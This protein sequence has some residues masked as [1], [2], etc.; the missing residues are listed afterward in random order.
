MNETDRIVLDLPSR[1]MNQAGTAGFS[2]G[3]QLLPNGSIF[4]TNPVSLQVRMPSADR[5]LLPF[6]G[7]FLLHTGLPNA[8]WKAIRRK[9]Q[10]HW[11]Q[12]D[13]PIWIHVI[14]Q[15]L[16]GLE[17]IVRDCEEIDGI[18]A[19]EL[20]LPP[21]CPRDWMMQLIQSARGEIPLV[22]HISLGEDLSVLS[23]LPEAVSAVT[24]GTP[25]GIV[26]EGENGRL[27]HGR[28]HG[29]GLFPQMLNALQDARTWQI[30]VILGGICNQ[31]DGE[32][33]LNNGAAAV[34]IDHLCWQGGLPTGL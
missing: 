1:W 15:D 13:S 18:A 21:A 19:I 3:N 16:A 25:R 24:L 5:N 11:H 17:G 26:P 31:K 7:G 23:S 6:P 12:S 22:L 30:P 14:S 10:S 4:V 2:P 29:P 9:Y 20:G 28:L 33:A 34:Q 27:I 32:T 8:G